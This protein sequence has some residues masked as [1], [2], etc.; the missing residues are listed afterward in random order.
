[1]LTLLFLSNPV[2]FNWQNYEKGGLELVISRTAGYKKGHKNFLI[3]YILPDQVWWCNIKQFL[4]YSKYYACRFMQANSW[5]HKSFHFHFFFWIW[6]V[7]NGRGKITKIWI[8]RERKELFRWKKIDCMYH[9]RKYCITNGG[10]LFREV[11]NIIL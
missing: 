5:H 1:M 4:S 6:K 2:L 7:W 9:Q 3:S 8:S 10:H 11:F